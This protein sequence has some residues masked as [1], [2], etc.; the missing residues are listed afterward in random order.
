MQCAA[1]GMASISAAATPSEVEAA[2]TNGGVT[3]LRKPDLNELA[4]CMGVYCYYGTLGTDR[5]AGWCLAVAKTR[6]EGFIEVNQRLL[7]FFRKFVV[8]RQRARS[9]THRWRAWDVAHLRAT[10]RRLMKKFVKLTLI[11]FSFSLLTS[12]HAKPAD[13]SG[14]ELLQPLFG[15]WIA[16]G[17]TQLGTGQGGFSFRPEL[18]GRVVVRRNVAEYQG[19]KAAGTRHD[20]LMIIFREGTAAALRA[21]YFDSEGHVI[22]YDLSFPAEGKAVFESESSQPGP[23]YRLSYS[24]DG[25]VLTGK[26]EIAIQ[27]QEFKTYLEWKAQRRPDRAK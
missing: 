8:A 23:K 22:R 13:E 11:A 15:E 26:F 3:S 4:L 2:L 18:N 12:G 7:R 19:G 27:G 9:Y 10:E 14:F 21:I 17:E 5:H 6:G 24:L 16:S 25:K 1:V 20:D